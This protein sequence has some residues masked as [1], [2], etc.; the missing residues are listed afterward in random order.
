MA[1]NLAKLKQKPKKTHVTSRASHYF[2]RHKYVPKRGNA[3]S[4][5]STDLSL[6]NKF[7]VLSDLHGDTENV[8]EGYVEQ[9]TSVSSTKKHISKKSSQAWQNIV[10]HVTNQ[11]SN[12]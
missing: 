6:S 11:K 7:A 10:K 3:N 5:I 2:K 9:S 12:L 4:T 8:H 1:N